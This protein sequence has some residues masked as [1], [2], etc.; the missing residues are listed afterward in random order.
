MH[1]FCRKCSRRAE[2][3][4]YEAR[5]VSK[6]RYRLHI[7][8]S[9]WLAEVKQYSDIVHGPQTILDRRYDRFSFGPEVPKHKD[10]L[11][12]EYIDKF[13]HPSAG[14]QKINYNRHL[15]AVDRDGGFFL[16]TV[17]CK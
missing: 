11:R 13:S 8:P 7:V 4:N 10:H 15:Y 17:S 5:H 1:E 14:Q 2:V 16:A 9:L 3:S 12:T 6:Q